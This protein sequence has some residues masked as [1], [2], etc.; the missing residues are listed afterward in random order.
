MNS[1]R[2]KLFFNLE[3]DSPDVSIR[4]PSEMDISMTNT[5]SPLQSG[6]LLDGTPMQVI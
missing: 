6:I 5:Q 2:R 3:D 4:S 1:L